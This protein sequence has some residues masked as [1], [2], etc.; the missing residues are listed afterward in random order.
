[1]ICN[2]FLLLMD[3]GCTL[4]ISPCQPLHAL[5]CPFNCPNIVCLIHFPNIKLPCRIIQANLERIWRYPKANDPEVFTEFIP[6]YQSSL[7]CDF[8]ILNHL[9]TTLTRPVTKGRLR[10]PWENFLPFW[11]T[12]GWGE[13]NVKSFILEW[14]THTTQ[15]RFWERNQN[16]QRWIGK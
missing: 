3:G 11:K 6:I 16:E 12:S 4:S 15:K 1:M 9:V 7:Q 2:L 10:P 8:Y 5:G 13:I 14:N